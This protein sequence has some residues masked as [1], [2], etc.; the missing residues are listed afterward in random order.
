MIGIRPLPNLLKAGINYIGDRLYP[1]PLSKITHR[2][3][4]SYGLALLLAGCTVGPNYIPPKASVP[5]NWSEQQDKANNRSDA[6]VQW[7]KTFNDS[8]LDSLVAQAVKSNLDLRIAEARVREARAQRGVVSADLWPS[9][10]T[11][12]SYTRSR[13]SLGNS[14]IPSLAPVERNLY[15]VGFDAKWEIDL[16]G[17]KRRAVEAANADIG[18]AVEDQRDV[19]VTLLAEVARNYIEARGFQQR[20]KIARN[21]IQSQQETVTITKSQ[22]N[23][24][25]ISELDVTQAEALLATTQSQVPALESSLKQAIHRIGILLGQK[26]GTLLTELTKEASIPIAPTTA[27]PIGL[28]S[29]LLRHRPDVRRAERELAAA[30]ARI[31]VATADLFPKFSLTGNFGLQSEN[32]NT[33]MKTGTSRFWSMGPTVSWPIFDA[34]RIRANIHV[35]NE[36]QEQ[37][38]LKYEKAVLTSLEDVENALVAYAMEQVRRHNLAEAVS[39]NRRAVELANELFTKGLANFLN[40]LDA[41]R[42]LYK[43]ED[44]LVQSDRTVSLNLVILYKA[45]GGGWEKEP[46]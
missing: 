15:Q 1:V 37:A 45:L 46:S 29:D 20:L 10:N 22:F 35:Q 28:P 30:T 41:E 34:G 27:V 42:S 43:S 38:L 36:R 31:G 40:V 44:D 19:M 25:L 6:I 23:A 17:G 11:S 2:L 7:W 9:I 24:G 13:R 5:D 4:L 3:L 16:F 14:A 12:T 39:A 18:A 32:T 8:K 21:N 33:L 26:P